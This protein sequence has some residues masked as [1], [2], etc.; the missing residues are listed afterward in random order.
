M[1]SVGGVGGAGAGGQENIPAQPPMIF[2][3]VVARYSPLVLPVV[4]HDLPKNYMKRLPKFTREGNLTATKHIAFFDQFIDILGVENED[5]YTRML[6]QTFEGEVRNWFRGL[7]VGS[8]PSYNDLETSFIR[9][10]GEKK[11]HIYYLT[12]FGA[13]KNKTPESI[14]EFIQIFNKLYHNILV[15]VK[16]SHPAEK[17]TFTGAFDSDFTLLLRERISTNLAGMQD[18]AIKIESNTMEFDKLK[19]KVEMGERE[20]KHFK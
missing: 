16:P 15:E 4:L 2:S 12:E 18:D 6:V 7:P 20:P 9:Q 3:K 13:L 14:L 10:W 19:T 5:V 1:V 8:I 17:V 11:D